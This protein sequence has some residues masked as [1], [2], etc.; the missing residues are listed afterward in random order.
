MPL[1][2]FSGNVRSQEVMIIPACIPE[3]VLEIK[4]LDLSVL[5]NSWNIWDDLKRNNYCYILMLNAVGYIKSF[6]AL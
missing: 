5:E 2:F 6:N 3:S 1:V 4:I